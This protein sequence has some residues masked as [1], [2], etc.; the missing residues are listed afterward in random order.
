VT[1]NVLKGRILE[2]KKRKRRGEE[3]FFV[4]EKR[5]GKTQ[6]ICDKNP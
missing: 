6:D 2:N 3:V 1:R 4:L 5:I